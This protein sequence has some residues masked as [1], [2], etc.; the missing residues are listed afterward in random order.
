MVCNYCNKQVTGS[1]TQVKGQFSHLKGNG[2]DPC[3]TIS[4]QT[5]EELFIENEAAENRKPRKTSE[6]N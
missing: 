1:Y 4:D 3:N 6:A 5:R 2:V